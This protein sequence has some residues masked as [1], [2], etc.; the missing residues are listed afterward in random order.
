M[1]ALAP[2]QKSYK[3]VTVLTV[4][5]FLCLLLIS[6]T[7][8][9]SDNESSIEEKTEK[10]NEQI[11]FSTLNENDFTLPVGQTKVKQEGVN[12]NKELTFKIT[13]ADGK[14]T[15]R[16]K[17]SE[18]ITLQPIPKIIL[19]GTKSNT[20]PIDHKYPVQDSGYEAGYNWAEDKGINDP[21]E[22]SGNSESF[23]EGC[24]AYAEE[25]QNELQDSSDS[26]NDTGY[27]SGYD[28]SEM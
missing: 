19:A 22:C 26:Y 24:Q 3:W 25:Q 28:A 27:D 1:E 16:E 7:S 18:A 21:G 15:M 11:P 20:P 23:I 17:V 6:S 2:Y 10:K 14:E 8:C 4:A 5:L 12:G 13:Y 9:G